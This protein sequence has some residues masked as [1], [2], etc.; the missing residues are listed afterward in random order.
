M[1]PTDEEL[2][3]AITVFEEGNGEVDDLSL[4]LTAARSYLELRQ[5]VTSEEAEAALR[6]IDMYGG[7]ASEY[8]T[9]MV[10]A[11]KAFVREGK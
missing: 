10:R 2:K 9:I 3:T 8:K 5:A 11:L 1:T 7:I 4:L 6:Y